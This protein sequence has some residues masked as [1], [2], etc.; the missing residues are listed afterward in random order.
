MDEMA[1]D[2]DDA[3]L[4]EKAKKVAEQ[5]ALKPKKAAQYRYGRGRGQRVLGYGAAYSQQMP[6]IAG[7]Q[8]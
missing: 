3:K 2:D 8:V 5:M 7:A 1:E 6:S 4:L